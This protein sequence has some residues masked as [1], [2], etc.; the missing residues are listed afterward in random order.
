[1]SKTKTECGLQALQ[2]LR[3]VDG[4][5]T[6]ETNDTTTIEEAYDQVKAILYNKHLVSWEDTAVPDDVIM[7]LCYLMAE[8]RLTLFTPPQ[9]VAQMIVL[10]ASEAVEDIT[11]ALAL[12][13]VYE[14]IPSESF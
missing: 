11:E 7:P 8:S 9:V 12:D 5:A 3:A 2:M 14:T 6:P 4:D 13:Y 10:K 1:M